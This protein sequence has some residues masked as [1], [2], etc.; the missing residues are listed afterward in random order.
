MVDQG[1]FEAVDVAI[2][3]HPFGQTLTARESLAVAS[4]DLVFH[5]KAGPRGC[6]SGAGINALDSGSPDL[7]RYQRAASAAPR[8]CANPRHYSRRGPGE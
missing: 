1:V 2:M 3:I 5:G 8:G 7:Q 4:L 6:L